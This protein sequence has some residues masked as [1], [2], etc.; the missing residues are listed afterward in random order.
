[1]K[2]FALM[3]LLGLGLSIPTH[4]YASDNAVA[5]MTGQK[6]VTSANDDIKNGAGSTELKTAPSSD[7]VMKPASGKSGAF[8]SSSTTSSSDSATNPHEKH[9][10]KMAHRPKHHQNK[11]QELLKG[12]GE[13]LS[14]LGDHKGVDSG[15]DFD[16]SKRFH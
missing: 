12:D 10:K 13:P 7:T 11:G 4:G 2:K 5:K 16:N 1:M 15:F 9:P 3:A 14:K 6:H 8:S